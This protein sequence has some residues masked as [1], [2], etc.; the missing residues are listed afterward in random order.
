[1]KHNAKSEI[2]L[3]NNERTS[4]SLLFLLRKKKVQS[5][6]IKEKDLLQIKG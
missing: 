1:M 4:K 6:F 2:N 5:F 3:G